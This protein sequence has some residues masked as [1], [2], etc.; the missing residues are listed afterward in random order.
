SRERAEAHETHVREVQ[1]QES[2]LEKHGLALAAA[3][4]A[5]SAAAQSAGALSVARAALEREDQAE[6]P[7]RAQLSRIAVLFEEAAASA[8]LMGERRS[9][10]D[11]SVDQVTLELGRRE[12]EIRLCSARLGEA[13]RHR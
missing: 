8:R 1:R 10:V 5:W 6:A 9:S 2:L 13:I 7:L 4:S 11:E 3:D 12:E